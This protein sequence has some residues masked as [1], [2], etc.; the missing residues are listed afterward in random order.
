MKSLFKSISENQ[1]QFEI[2]G[3]KFKSHS[4]LTYYD[5]RERTEDS[6]AFFYFESSLL[7]ETV[8][9]VLN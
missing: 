5:I 9:T 4:E 1:K 2:Y 7:K 3:I 6:R 8:N